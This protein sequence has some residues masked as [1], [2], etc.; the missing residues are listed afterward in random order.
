MNFLGLFLVSGLIATAQA[1][2]NFSF[3]T[4]LKTIVV[5]KEGFGFYLRE[6]SAKLENGWATTNLVPRAVKGTLWVYSK[7]PNDRIDTVILTPDNRVEFEKSE[8]IK[9]LLANKIGLL[10][11]VKTA[12]KEL[13]GQLH[14]LLNDMMLL[15]S[16]GNYVAIEYKNIVS[17][18]LESFPV[19][20]KLN[21][22]NPNAVTNIGL[23]YVQEGIRWEPSYLLEMF[24][25]KRARLTLRGT[26]L[27]LDEELKNSNVVFVV[28]APNLVNRGS[29][30]DLLQGFRSGIIPSDMMKSVIDPAANLALER[31]LRDKAPGA[32]ETGLR[33][34][35]GFGGGGAM[36]GSGTWVDESGELQYYT[37]TNFSLR[38]G[39][40]AMATI[41]EIEIPVTPLF[42]W[43]ADGDNVEFILTLDNTSKQ[44]FTTGSVF[45]VDNQK[46]VGQQNIQYTAPGDKTEIRMARGIGLKVERRE[47]E[48]KRGDPIKIGEQQ[49][50]PITL[51]GALTIENFRDESADVRI[52][53]TLLGKVLELGSGG[54]V[55]DSKVQP[56]NPNSINTV[57]WKISVVSKGKTTIEYQYESYSAIGR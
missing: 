26:L 19:K 12:D 10:L 24:T 44:P 34:G 3:K 31:E 25:G 1:P 18:T 14:T 56:A 29:L 50:L 37:K 36:T 27:N 35:G 20:I 30:D 11:K 9:T 45:V 39:E 4:D 33:G 41:F 5:F 2:D 6:G 7:N 42:E 8:Q 13:S 49:F 55:K 32:P 47:T 40:K 43:N 23:A 51:K 21:T 57:E 54:V 52:T 48:V 46:P 15:K 38:P 17:V 28:G 16:E 22:T 53:R